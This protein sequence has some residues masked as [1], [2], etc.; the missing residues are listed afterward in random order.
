VQGFQVDMSLRSDELSVKNLRRLIL[1]EENAP[2]SRFNDEAALPSMAALRSPTTQ[3]IIDIHSNSNH[4]AVLEEFMVEAEGE[5][6]AF[7]ELGDDAER[8]VAVPIAGTAAKAVNDI[9]RAR[10]I[11]G[12]RY[13][14]GDA[15]SEG[16]PCPGSGRSSVNSLDD[17]AD[18][19]RKIAFTYPR[20][21]AGNV[22]GVSKE[23]SAVLSYRPRPAALMHTTEAH[24]PVQHVAAL[25]N[26]HPATT[27]AS[28]AAMMA[29][30]GAALEQQEVTYGAYKVAFDRDTEEQRKQ[31]AR[32]SALLSEPL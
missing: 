6:V 11:V 15:C 25:R 10:Q 18:V 20:D 26:P 3:T 27:R 23:G 28:L 29:A 32:L 13:A 9:G 14:D 8:T 7:Q 12:P 24:D 21:A 2:L 1:L 22:I 5:R 4:F 31:E 16:S 19:A 17:D 30:Q